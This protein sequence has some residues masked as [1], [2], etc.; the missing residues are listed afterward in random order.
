M[1]KLIITNPNIYATIYTITE[2]ITMMV[3]GKED[4]GPTQLERPPGYEL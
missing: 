2:I 1:D 3:I 4:I